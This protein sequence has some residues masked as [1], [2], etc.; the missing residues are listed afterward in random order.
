MTDTVRKASQQICTY[1]RPPTR[2]LSELHADGFEIGLIAVMRHF[3]MA[4]Q[5]PDSQ[6]WE[7]A[8]QTAV[9]RWGDEIGLPA[10]FKSSA[11]IRAMLKVR[12]TAFDYCDPLDLDQR[13]LVSDDEVL[14]IRMI[15]HMR[16]DNTT[17]A[18]D[19]VEQLAHGRMDPDLIR[20]GLALA[21]RFPAGI[22]AQNLR[23]RST[24]RPV[25]KIVN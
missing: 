19:A 22:T 17:A 23:G 8:F 11:L 7:L 9:E 24:K 5:Q 4:R 12:H 2:R 3:L 14:L 13:G 16:R 18:R 21:H 20:A 10:A 15:H 6:A 25:L 1:S